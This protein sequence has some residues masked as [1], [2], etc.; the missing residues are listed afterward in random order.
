MCGKSK[1]HEFSH[2]LE[3]ES[4]VVKF[5]IFKTFAYD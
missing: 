5:L 1:H 3:L 2:V 4:G